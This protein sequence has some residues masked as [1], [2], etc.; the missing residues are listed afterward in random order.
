MSSQHT[1]RALPTKLRTNALNN[2]FLDIFWPKK[3]KKES[4]LKY[5]S[6]WIQSKLIFVLKK[7]RWL[8]G[9]T[10]IKQWYIPYILICMSVYIHRVVFVFVKGRVVKYQSYT[11]FHSLRV[12]VD[13]VI[14]TRAWMMPQ[15]IF[16]AA[17]SVVI[18][19]CR[20]L[21]L[22]YAFILVSPFFFCLLDKLFRKGQVVFMTFVVSSKN[23]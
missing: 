15:N 2:L 3:K 11:T 19:I 8:C 9:K 22:S 5:Q 23:L 14:F 16:F 13:T 18:Y 4:W 17:V 12:V 7:Q 21:V 1:K 6:L 20:S 10:D